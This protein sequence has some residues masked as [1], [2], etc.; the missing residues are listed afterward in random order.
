VDVSG[1]REKTLEVILDTE[2]CEALGITASTVRNRISTSESSRV[3]A[4]NIKDHNKRVFV[5][6]SAE[7]ESLVDLE[8]LIILENGPVRLRDVAEVYF[9]TKEETSYSRVNG[10]QAVTVLLTRDAQANM[11]DLSH[12]TQELIKKLNKELA[13]KDV[14]IVIRQNMAEIMEKNIDLI[15]NLSIVGGL[16]AVFLLWI[17]LKNLRLVLAVALAIP[18]SVYSAFNFFYAYGISINA[19]TLIGMALAI[20]MLLDNSVVVMENIYRL[21]AKKMHPDQAATQGTKEVMRAIIAATLTT[22]TVFLPFVFAKD[23]FTRI[24]GHHIGVSIISTLL[25]S[26]VLALLLIPMVTHTFLKRSKKADSLVFQKVSIHNRLIQVY[27]LLLKSGMRF[28]ARTI[29]GSLFV[30]FLAL[31]ISLTVSMSNME[32]ADQ[33]E[34]KLYVSMPTGATLDKTDKVV[35]EI[36]SKI[37]SISERQDVVSQIYTDEAVLTIKL[38]EK[39][40]SIDNR[41]IPNIKG[42]IQERVKGISEADIGFDPPQK[43]RRFSGDGGDAGNDFMEFMGI[44][45]QKESVLVKG[46]DFDRMTNVANDIKYGL[47]GLSSIKRANINIASSR[48]EVH[49]EFDKQ[50]MSRFGISAAAVSS[51]LNSFQTEFSTNVRYKQGNDEFDI[52]IRS[53]QAVKEKTDRNMDELKNMIIKGSDNSVHKLDNISKLYFADG[54]SSIKRVNQDKQISISYRFLDEINSSSDLQEA[55]REE[56]DQMIAS[57]KLPGGVAVEVVH[58]KDDLADFK[59]LILA[60]FILIYMILASVFESFA[61]PVVLMFSIPLAALGSL[62]ALILTGSNLLTPNTLI[63]FLILLG[64]VVNNGI[65]LIDYTRLLRKEGYSKQRALMMAGLARVRPILITAITT[66]I[67]LFP[68]AMGKA[69]YVSM[70]GTPFAITVI[71]GLTMSTLLT[72]VFIPTFYSGLENSLNWIRS[73]DWRISLAQMIAIIAATFAIYIEMDSLLYQIIMFLIAIIGVPAVTW[74]IMNSLRQANEKLIA[75]DEPITIQLRNLVKIY[76]RDSRF[77]REWKNGKAIRARLGMEKDFSSWKEFD[78]LIWQLPLVG[79]VIYFIYIHLESRLWF[80][81][82]PILLYLLVIEI[83]KPIR[84]F[85]SHLKENKGKR[86]RSFTNKLFY[87]LFFWLFPALNFYTYSQR[88][89]AL[90]WIIVVG[91]F[92]YCILLIAVTSHMLHRDQVNVNRIKGPFKGIRKLFFRFVLVIPVIG[93]KKVPFKALKGV[94]LTIENGMFGLLGPNGA[95]KTTMMRIICGILDQ[96]YGK[97]FINGYDTAEKREELQGLIGYLPQEFG[98]YENMSAYEFLHYQGMLKNLKDKK[99]REERIEYVLKSVHMYEVRND[100]IGS[101]SGG[102]KQRIGIAQILLHLP[103]ILVVDEP[104][105]GLDPRERIRFR[106]L[107]VE[108]SRE[109]IVIFSTHIIEDIS[110]SCNQVA[111]V[112]KGELKYL[113]TPIDMNRIAE[114][115]V[116]QFTATMEEFAELE[117]KLT[118]IHHMKDGNKIRIRCMADNQPDEHAIIVSPVLEDAYLYLLKNGAGEKRSTEFRQ[119]S[120]EQNQLA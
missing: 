69:E 9:G 37:E 107:L 26:L 98:M 83:W 94:S 14:E 113:G 18:I 82:L 108:L 101:F 87:R 16:L 118:I 39:Y 54:M 17:F 70:I 15:I 32:E 117:K 1:G 62:V 115:K 24:L 116:W 48:P 110:S 22:I 13:A 33:E 84:M 72:L 50:I 96:S 111:V 89:I 85:Y 100:K 102:M 79:F 34:F 120:T 61:T 52:I 23:F 66:I 6:I 19:L 42:D 64:V 71:G 25:I 21:A 93:K 80:V 59:F 31:I 35:A 67:A 109:R 28:P 47:D 44:G 68:L 112:Q 74:F 104:T 30:F 3:Y 78:Q 20:G 8:D 5:N 114:G 81:L 10:K 60:A 76:N 58:E 73:L 99:I 45:S 43:S 51:E 49:M 95:G 2:R 90:G 40:K 53:P 77:I 103:R 55:S 29:I 105:A 106:N 57:L 56:V 12:K 86:Y 88:G 91:I 4:G 27:L 75:T 63:G 119:Q 46:Q 92:W 38:K 41:T 36:E 11:I 65:I 7:Y 97:I